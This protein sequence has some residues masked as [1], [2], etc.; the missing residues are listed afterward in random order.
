MVSGAVCTSFNAVVVV[1]VCMQDESTAFGELLGLVEVQDMDPERAVEFAHQQYGTV[2]L[3]EY[4]D[5]AREHWGL[6]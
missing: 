2:D 4:R 3:G 6:E 5:L 1:V